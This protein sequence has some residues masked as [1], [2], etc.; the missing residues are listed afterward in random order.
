LLTQDPTQETPE[1]QLTYQKT[2]WT[3]NDGGIT[4]ADDWVARV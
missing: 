3:W 1:V 2:T 4:A